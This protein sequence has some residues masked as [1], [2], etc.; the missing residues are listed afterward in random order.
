[1]EPLTEMRV[2]HIHLLITRE[3]FTLYNMDLAASVDG[4]VHVEGK[5]GT[6]PNDRKVDF[7]FTTQR[8]PI[9][10]LIPSD[11]REHLAGLAT[12]TIHWTGENTKLEH[13]AGEAEFTIETARIHDLRF[14]EKIATLANDKS[15]REIL[16]DICQFDSQW[17]YPTI[18]FNHCVMEEK[19]KFRAEGEVAVNREGS[20]RGTIEL[21]VAPAL[22]AFL[23]APVVKEVFP[24]E[25][26]GYVWTTVHLAGTL[27]QPQL[28]LN[29]RVMDAIKEHP[30]VA[31]KLF[32]RQLGDSFRGI[33]GEK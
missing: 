32:F 6:Q 29:D 28:D 11:W 22:L 18:E 25:K 23:T 12:S 24:R 2:D 31:L 17:N 1:M 16:L 19:G 10:N 33:F 4:R 7:R 3:L 26:D 5:A 8:V 15:L 14:L 27:E 9:D 21:G 20:L 30:T 13:S